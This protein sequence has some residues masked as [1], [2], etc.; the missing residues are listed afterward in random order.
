MEIIN[1]YYLILSILKL[2]LIDDYINNQIKIYRI[3]II[4]KWE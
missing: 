2:L 3:H 4:I 1:I